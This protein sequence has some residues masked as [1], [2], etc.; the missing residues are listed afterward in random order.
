MSEFTRDA[1]AGAVLLACLASAV[2]CLLR[3]RMMSAR[4]RL[5]ERVRLTCMGGACMA[6]G[7]SPLVG[8]WHGPYGLILSAAVLLSLCLDWGRWRNGTP[9]EFLNTERMPYFY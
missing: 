6:F 9:G 7:L 5:M 8:E 3:L 1:Y 4:Y 2:I